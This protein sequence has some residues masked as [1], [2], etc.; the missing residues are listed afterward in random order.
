MAKASGIDDFNF[1]LIGT[2]KA[3]FIGYISSKDPT[4]VNELALVQGSQNVIKTL[5]ETIANRCGRKLYDA[6]DSSLDGVVA[7]FEWETS[8]GITYLIRVLASGKLQAYVNSSWLTLIS[9]LVKTR[10]VFDT[11]WNDTQKLDELLMVNGEENIRSWSGGVTTFDSVTNI[12]TGAIW[13]IKTGASLSGV[14]AVG[15][16]LTV[17]G[18]TGGSIIVN[19]VSTPYSTANPGIALNA[20]GSGYS[21]GSQTAAG[22]GKSI[23]ITITEVRTIYS[24]K[25][26]GTTT[27]A[28]DRFTNN[29]AKTIATNASNIPVSVID[30]GNRLT[31]N[32]EEYAYFAGADSD[33]LNGVSG[34]S[35][36]NLVPSD[37]AAGDFMYQSVV[38]SDPPVSGFAADFIRVLGNQLFVGSYSNRTIYLSA[39]SDFTDFTNSGS[40]I[41]GD[42][43]L[44]ILDENPRGMIAKQNAMYVAAGNSD[45]Y[46]VTPNVIP[47]VS[48]TDGSAT[49]FIVTQVEKKR[50]ATNTAALAHE[51]IDT[52]GDDIIFLDQDN[53]LRSFGTFRNL[54]QPKYPSLSQQIRQELESEDFTGGQIRA[55]DDYIYLVA[56]ISGKVYLRQTRDTVN[57]EGNVVAERLWHPPQTWNIATIAVANGQTYGYSSTNPQLYQLWDTEQFH[58]DTPDGNAPYI[59]IMRLAYQHFGHR[60]KMGSFDKAYFEGYILEHSDL[61]ARFL[62]DYQAAT[63]YQTKILSNIDNTPVLYGG[64][65]VTAIGGSIIGNT[66]LGGGIRDANYQNQLHKFRAITNLTQSDCFEYQ[67]ELASELPDSQWE[68][69]CLGTDAGIANN[70]P[71][72]IQLLY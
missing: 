36:P 34:Y 17:P 24:V 38:E 53:Q 15:D 52:L 14:F 48:F 57:D 47:A 10:F 71:V 44:V 18:G 62:Y 22:G 55:V 11:W 61:E 7:S 33:T 66:T 67:I 64:D 39:D 16:V 72:Q 46:V 68:I 56:P 54:F 42:P 12:Q 1:N 4:T 6:V 45:W 23:D 25:K 32:S 51:F 60:Y 13:S 8:T 49:R 21:I 41:V 19:S 26:Q 59:S 58:D 2:D 70:Y 50:G 43:D 35:D 65:G 3:P 29:P 28:E 30:A 20:L 9:D 5:S 31:V 63:D 40:Y 37:A 27:W 69:L